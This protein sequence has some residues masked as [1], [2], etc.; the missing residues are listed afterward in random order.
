[1]RIALITLFL[2]LGAASTPWPWSLLWL[3]VPVALAVTLLLA[4]RFGR[5]A[6]AVPL[7]LVAAAGALSF[8]GAAL[9][10]WFTAW[11]P[12]AAAIGAWMGMR[13]E[14]G[15]PAIGERAWMLAPLLALAA[16]LPVMPG[17]TDAIGRLD[18][19]MMAD[20]ERVMQTVPAAEIPALIRDSSKQMKSLPEA[21]RRRWWLF[22]IPNAMFFGMA[23][24]VATGRS[25]AARFSTAL[26]WPPL[27]RS[28][29]H[30]WRL[31]DLALVPL[32]AGLTLLIFADRAWQPGAWT[33]LLNAALG[34]SV[35]GV[36]VVESVLLSRGMPPVFVALMMLFVIAVSLLWVLPA[37]AVVGLSDVWLDYRRLEPAPQGEA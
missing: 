25:L 9:P 37:I 36:A 21:E 24:L 6:L 32:I 22:S 12:L 26:R 35:Q 10:P 5:V 16:M 28:P 7:A 14:G 8:G 3:T 1:M 34:Y 4:W 27:S 33:L 23:M 17:F 29:L 20:Q 18:V 11:T 30:R 15:G 13:E 31:P 2:L 19:R